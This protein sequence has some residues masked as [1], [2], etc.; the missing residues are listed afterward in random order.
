MF[1]AIFLQLGGEDQAFD[2]IIDIGEYF[3]GFLEQLAEFGT[4]VFG[5]FGL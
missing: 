2:F 3:Q 1:K 4:S 5:V